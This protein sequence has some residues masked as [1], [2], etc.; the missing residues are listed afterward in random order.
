MSHAARATQ[1]RW[2]ADVFRRFGFPPETRT[3][4]DAI[5]AAIEAPSR[6]RIVGAGLLLYGLR[7]FLALE[8]DLADFITDAL[9][10]LAVEREWLARSEASTKG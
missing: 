4:R 6:D 7:E 9:A 3:I 8:P 1:R 2:S 5:T 10:I